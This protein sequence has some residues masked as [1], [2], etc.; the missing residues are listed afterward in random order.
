MQFATHLPDFLYRVS[1]GRYNQLKLPLSCEVVEKGGFW[2]PDLQGEGIPQISA[3]RFQI[4]LTSEHVA[5]F[6]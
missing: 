3:M 1:F 2:V 4:A 6:G 5:S